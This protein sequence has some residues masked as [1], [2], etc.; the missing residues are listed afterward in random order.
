MVN[1]GDSQ[2]DISPKPADER[3]WNS[4]EKSGFPISNGSHPFIN[5]SS[6]RHGSE[7]PL[8]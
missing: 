5:P 3:V 1:M 2:V 6:A 8:Q 7:F 4:G